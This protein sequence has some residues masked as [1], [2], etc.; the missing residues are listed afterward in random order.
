MKLMRK[1][2]QIKSSVLIGEKFGQSHEQPM[3]LREPLQGTVGTPALWARMVEATLSPR[4]HMA[5]C[6]GPRKKNIQEEGKK[7]FYFK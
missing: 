1:T 6:D 2:N 4:A 3:G 5:S 7:G